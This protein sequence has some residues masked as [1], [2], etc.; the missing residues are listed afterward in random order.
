MKQVPASRQDARL[1]AVI[2]ARCS[3]RRLPG[4]VLRSVQARPMLAHT[5]ERLRSVKRI[6]EVVIAT[7]VDRS[8]D[9][10]AEFAAESGAVC[11]RGSLEDVLG[12]IHE[13]ADA[14]DADAVI[15]ISGDSPLIDPVIVSTAIALFTEGQAELVTNVFPRTFPKGQSVEILSRTALKRLAAEATEG[16]DREHVTLYAYAHPERFIITNF[17]AACPRPEL[18]LSVDTEADMELAN[19]LMALSRVRLRFPTVEELINL[20]DAMSEAS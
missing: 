18:Q 5:L 20:V 16:T 11:W 13:A 6:D 4:K 3:S 9:A 1:V 14:H 12:R 17:S 10:V 7:S 19:K 2:T 15:R 8:D